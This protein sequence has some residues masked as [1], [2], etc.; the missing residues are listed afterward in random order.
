MFDN[1]EIIGNHHWRTMLSWHELTDA[2]RKHLL[3][4]DSFVDAPNHHLY[5]RFKGEVIGDYHFIRIHNNPWHPNPP[6]WQDPYH[7][8]YPC[9]GFL[10]GLL[11]RYNDPDSIEIRAQIYTYG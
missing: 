2:E 11:I 4:E 8:Y 6:D 10:G 7:G 1:I 5:V 3:E 9:Y